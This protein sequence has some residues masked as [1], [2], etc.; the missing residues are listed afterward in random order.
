MFITLLIVTFLI[1]V[2][3]TH[4]IAIGFRTSIAKI[5]ERIFS[6]AIGAAWQRY[7]TYA[8]YVVGIPGGVRIW[9]LEKYIS[10]RSKDEAILVLNVDRWVLEVYRTI[11]GTLQSTAWLL[12]VFFLV[13]LFA[14]VIV[15]VSERRG[16]PSESSRTTAT[17]AHPA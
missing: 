3:I 16:A 7:I 11:I 13:A 1:A 15:R 2:V 9:E 5:L 6:E 14:Y 4:V 12:L 10:P 8:I 17:A